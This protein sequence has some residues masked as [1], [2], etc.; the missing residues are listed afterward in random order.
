M[1]RLDVLASKAYL[2]SGVLGCQLWHEIQTDRIRGSYKTT[3]GKVTRSTPV[4]GN[5]DAACRWVL[6]WVWSM[7]TECT[8][9]ECPW[10][11]LM[12]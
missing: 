3:A 6:K 12:G 11:A 7:H 2:P 4:S 8:G 9:T 10:P 5:P 1:D